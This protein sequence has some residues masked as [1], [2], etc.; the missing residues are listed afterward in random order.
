MKG[1]RGFIVLNTRADMSIRIA[2]AHIVTYGESL[3]GSG[4]FIE[5]VIGGHFSVHQSP[6]A[7]DRLIADAQ[8]AS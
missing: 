7:I 8:V 6:E 1:P 4:T 5:P 2:V 3:D